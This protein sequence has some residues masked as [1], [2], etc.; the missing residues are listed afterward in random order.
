MAL[1]TALA[2]AGIRGGK[3]VYIFRW[4]KCIFEMSSSTENPTIEVD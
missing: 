3:D 1:W 4:W 2:L